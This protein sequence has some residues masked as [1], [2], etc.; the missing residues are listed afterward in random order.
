VKPALIL[1]A[2][3]EATDVFFFER[4]FGKAGLP[5][6][7]RVVRDGQQAMDYLAGAGVFA[8]RERHPLPCLALLDINMPRKSGFDVLEWVRRQSHLRFLPV[9]MLTSSSHPADMEKARALT[10]DDYLL[11]PSDPRQLVPLITALHARWL[12]QPP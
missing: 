7:L 11:K 10:A 8:D 5:Y 9:L 1:Y 3:D 4:A 2:E 12:S 6:T